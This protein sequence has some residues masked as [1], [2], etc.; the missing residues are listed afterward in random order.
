MTAVADAP[1]EVIVR[2][3]N[4][5]P[6]RLPPYAVIVLNDDL[7]TFEYVI[8]CFQKVFGY[9]ITKCVELATTIHTQGRALVWSGSKEVAE[10]KREQIIGVGT[11]FYA[12]KPVTFPLGVEIEPM[13]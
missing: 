9:D 1:P 13:P 12:S 2:P 4:P 11:D 7:H 3:K 8:E 6:K 5:S 10:L